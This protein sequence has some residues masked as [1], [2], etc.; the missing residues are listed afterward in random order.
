MRSL[1]SG[2]LVVG[3]CNPGGKVWDDNGG[4]VEAGDGEEG[5]RTGRGGPRAKFWKVGFGSLEGKLVDALVVSGNDCLC[6]SGGHHSGM[7]SSSSSKRFLGGANTE[8][9]TGIVVP[10]FRTLDLVVPLL[11]TL[12]LSFVL[13]KKGFWGSRSQIFFNGGIPALAFK[14]SPE[15]FKRSD[16]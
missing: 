13:G 16:L 9:L 11:G 4:R 6:S 3:Q 5:R 2:D 7:S 10:L 15:R 14:G 8:A 12:D 1:G